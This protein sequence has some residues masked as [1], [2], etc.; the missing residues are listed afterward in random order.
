MVGEVW[1]ISTIC[2]TW[3]SYIASVSSVSP[4]SNGDDKSTYSEEII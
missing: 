4:S 1:Y 2:V 3:V